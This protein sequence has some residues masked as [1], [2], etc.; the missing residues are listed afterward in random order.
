MKK[1]PGDFQGLFAMAATIM[2][3]NL[4]GLGGTRWSGV[5]LWF[6]RRFPPSGDNLV[7][8]HRLVEALVGQNGKREQLLCGLVAGTACGW[9]GPLN[10]ENA[11]HR[12]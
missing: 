6:L 5:N 7:R 9:E 2:Q 4:Q 8:F 10:R 12:V 3:R 1:A 11:V